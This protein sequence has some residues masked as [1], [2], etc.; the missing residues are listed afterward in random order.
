M[1]PLD[2]VL[3]NVTPPDEHGFCSLGT[4]VDTV[5]TAIRCGKT[6]IAQLNKRCPGPSATASSTSARST[7]ASRWTCRPTS[8]PIREIGDVERRIGEYVAELVQ[9][10]ATLQMGIGAIP[11]AVG[12]YL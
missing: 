5:I 11:S 2:A 7:S 8:T 1:L 4:A 10:E 9:D 3:I 6:V 12:L